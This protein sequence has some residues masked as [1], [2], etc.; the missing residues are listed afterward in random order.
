MASRDSP[1]RPKPPAALRAAFALIYVL[2]FARVFLI[3]RA[4]VAE[5]S[6]FIDGTSGDRTGNSFELISALKDGPLIP[7][8]FGSPLLFLLLIPFL[9]VTRRLMLR[10]YRRAAQV[11]TGY[12]AA[13]LILILVRGP[14]SAEAFGLAGLTLLTLTLLLWPVSRRWFREVAVWRQPHGP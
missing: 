12:L 4:I 11:F 13:R 14:Y 7:G 5:A 6:H 3:Q 8:S 2:I 10:G 9:I 1:T